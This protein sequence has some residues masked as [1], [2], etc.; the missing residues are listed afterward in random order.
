MLWLLRLSFPL[1]RTPAELAEVL[2][3][4]DLALYQAL[5]EIDGPWWG[6]REAAMSRQLC[7]VQAAAAGASIP[8]D[9]FAIEW[10]VGSTPDRPAANLLPS[11]EGLALFAARHGAEVPAQ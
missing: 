2:T 10:S 5:V 7:S 8:P 9:E 3:A 6:E 1:G 4:R 11:S